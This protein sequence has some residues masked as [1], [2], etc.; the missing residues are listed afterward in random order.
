M[1]ETSELDD[2]GH[3]GAPSD[4]GW[5]FVETRIPEATCL[6]I[7]VIED[8]FSFFEARQKNSILQ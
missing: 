2:I 1:G 4:Q 6:I 3:T 8:F 7:F 5:P